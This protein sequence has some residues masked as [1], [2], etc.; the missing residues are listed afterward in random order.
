MHNPGRGGS[1]FIFISVFS[2]HW[3]TSLDLIAQRTSL[4]LCV[5]FLEDTQSVFGW[6]LVDEPADLA[7]RRCFKV[8]TCGMCK[9]SREACSVVWRVPS[10]R[11]YMSSNIINTT[12]N[13]LLPLFFQNE[14]NKCIVW[15]FAWVWKQNLRLLARRFTSNAVAS[16]CW[17]SA[18]AWKCHGETR[19][20]LSREPGP[21]G[22]GLGSGSSSILQGGADP[23]HGP[24]GPGD[25]HGG[26]AD[27]QAS[28]ET[29]N[30]P[31]CEIRLVFE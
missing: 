12:W 11:N 31:N 9:L 24:R 2:S 23:E 7:I 20:N 16:L 17:A 22:P 1:D 30:G 15:P 10:T 25:H 8:R 28:Q 26:A 18:G 3:D 21:H 19:A 13:S 27:L 14:S 4:L 6:F 29:G 5:T